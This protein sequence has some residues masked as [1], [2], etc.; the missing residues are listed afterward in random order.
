MTWRPR[1]HSPTELSIELS[2][3][4]RDLQGRRELLVSVLERFQ[5]SGRFLAAEQEG[6][7]EAGESFR[8]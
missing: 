3:R 2:E 6:G 8:H 5:S 1:G 7:A 4:E